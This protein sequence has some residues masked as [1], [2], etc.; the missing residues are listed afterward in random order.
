MEDKKLGQSEAEK[1]A[2]RIDRV[3]AEYYEA[4]RE[5][6]ARSPYERTKA[7]VYAT[8]NE[9]AIENWNATY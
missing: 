3:K 6:Y 4:R 1:E 9:W 5:A 7:A 8:G 2:I